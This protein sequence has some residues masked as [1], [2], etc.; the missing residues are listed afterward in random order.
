VANKLNS[1]SDARCWRRSTVLLHSGD[2]F[3]LCVASVVMDGGAAS[4]HPLVIRLALLV[5]CVLEVSGA[6]SSYLL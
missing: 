6:A 3:V 4:M 2:G 1:N 5:S